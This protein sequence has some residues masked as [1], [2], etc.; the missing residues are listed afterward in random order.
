M[1]QKA[2]APLDLAAEALLVERAGSDT[3]QRNGDGDPGGERPL[4]FG[5][6][7]DHE[8]DADDA[9]RE[10]EP[11]PR[12]NP[13]A[14]QTIGQ[15]RRQHR[16]QRNDHRYEAGRHFLRDRDEYTTE[17]AAMHQ[18]SDHRAV[19]QI[20]ANWPFRLRDQHD[21]AQQYDHRGHP[22]GQKR[23]RLG[24]GHAEL[25]ADEAGRPQHQKHARRRENGE[26]GQRILRKTRRHG[27]PCLAQK[28]GTVGG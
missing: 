11:L 16:L 25:A 12:R 28:R 24:I 1:H 6:G 22:D 9:E 10:A 17:I 3:E 5:S 15:R 26:I 20:G 13:L 18:Q 7:M 2:G 23:H 19:P 8:I 4:T 27:R 21:H 14:E